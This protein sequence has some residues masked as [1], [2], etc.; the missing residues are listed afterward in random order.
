M[1]FFLLPFLGC[2]GANF[3]DASVVC[4]IQEVLVNIYDVVPSSGNGT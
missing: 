2:G 4:V 1:H 3:G